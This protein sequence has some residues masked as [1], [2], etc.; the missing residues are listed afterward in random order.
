MVLF[1]VWVAARSFLY[2]EPYWREYKWNI[3]LIYL[4]S[5]KRIRKSCSLHDDFADCF[6]QF[7][8]KE[9]RKK[10]WRMYFVEL[11]LL[12]L[13]WREATFFAV[14]AIHRQT[15]ASIA[16]TS[17]TID[18]NTM[19]IARIGWENA[20]NFLLMHVSAAGVIAPLHVFWVSVPKQPT[21]WVV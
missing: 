15:L 3:R 9:D 1:L 17:G 2:R 11:L 10:M 8:S 19:I 16:A 7:L 13:W 4:K 12:M 14:T 18:F 21:N 6:L 20:Q 5:W